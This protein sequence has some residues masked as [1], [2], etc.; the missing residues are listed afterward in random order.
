MDQDIKKIIYNVEEI[1]EEIPGDPN[2]VI[3]K[4]PPEVLEHTGWLEGDTLDIEI[5]NG[6]ISIK[7]HG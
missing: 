1:F 3:L 2:N 7:K 5:E 4:F 6:A